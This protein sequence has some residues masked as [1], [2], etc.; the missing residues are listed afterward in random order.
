MA[1]NSNTTNK[2]SEIRTGS[3]RYELSYS[4]LD[5]TSNGKFITSPTFSIGSHDWSL[6]CYPHGNKEANEHFSIF[7]DLRSEFSKDV[8][9]IFDFNLLRKDGQPS[10]VQLTRTCHVYERPGYGWGWPQ[11]V[12]FD[13][14]RDLYV[15]NDDCIVFICTVTVLSATMMVPKSDLNVHFGNLLEDEEISDVVFDVN[16]EIFHAH[17]VV[18][19]ARSPVFKAELFGPM[20]INNSE[21]VK[22]YD[23]EPVVFRFLLRFICTDS[24]PDERENEESDE[25]GDVMDSVVMSQHLLVAADRYALDRLKLICES[26]LCKNISVNNVATTFVLA[27]QHNCVRLIAI[28]YRF[29][30]KN[31]T[32]IKSTDGYEHLKLSCPLIVE[33]IEETMNQF[34]CRSDFEFV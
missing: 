11:F 4:Q 32:E 10:K 3:Y 16:G 19:A 27:E 22:I 12:K 9:A 1:S 18:L 8:S 7:L 20:K 17:K 23:M 14:L 13:D 30:S 15:N 26:S 33:K 2:I 28:C 6:T 5:E 24:L 21:N 31:Y 34:I 29:I 25:G